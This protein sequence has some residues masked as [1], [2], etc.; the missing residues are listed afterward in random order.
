MFE[1]TSTMIAVEKDCDAGLN[2]YVW[3]PNLDEL[4]EYAGSCKN[5]GGVRRVD[6]SNPL[7]QKIKDFAMK[8][9][10]FFTMP[11]SYT[12][13]FKVD[14]LASS[15]GYRSNPIINKLMGGPYL[16]SHA[17]KLTRMGKTITT[18]LLPYPNC[19]DQGMFITPISL[20]VCGLGKEALD[21]DATHDPFVE[22]CGCVDEI[23]RIGRG[24][25]E[26]K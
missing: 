9:D 17:D 16:N 1:D 26:I 24:V 5:M 22:G 21:L 2:A 19:Y 12:L 20:D 3:E 14:D 4:V 6:S 23:L 7:V 10:L 11:E 8:E 25:K 18:I 13:Y 15:T